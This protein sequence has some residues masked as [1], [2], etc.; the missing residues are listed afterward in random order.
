VEQS[1]STSFWA[2][3]LGIYH[4][5]FDVL[6]CDQLGGV[7][8]KVFSSY[9][10]FIGRAKNILHLYK[11]HWIVLLSKKMVSIL[12]RNTTNK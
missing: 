6:R 1:I 4:P 12:T 2:K 11:V 8:K 10:Y 7:E 3:E 9:E 5:L